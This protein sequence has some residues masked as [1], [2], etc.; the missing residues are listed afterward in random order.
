MQGMAVEVNDQA[1]QAKHKGM[2]SLMYNLHWTYSQ[3]LKTIIYVATAT[4]QDLRSIDPD[5]YRR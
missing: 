1:T 2:E 3:A 4:K 5:L